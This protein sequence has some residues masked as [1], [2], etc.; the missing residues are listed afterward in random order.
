[1]TLSMPARPTAMPATLV[2]SR[3]EEEE[4]LEI[5]REHSCSYTGKLDASL[6][7]L[8]LKKTML[9]KTSKFLSILTVLL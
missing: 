3:N 7:S 2:D 8:G 4:T 9:A 5:S 1:M 6:A